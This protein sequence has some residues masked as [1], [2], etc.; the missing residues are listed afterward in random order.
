MKESPIIF[1]GPMVRAILAGRK[2]QTRRII[3]NPE[4]LQGLM[5]AGE[6][7]A[8]CPY[9]GPGDLLYVRESF[10]FDFDFGKHYSNEHQGVHSRH[11]FESYKINY[12]ADGHFVEF[13]FLNGDPV[14]GT[15]SRID[16]ETLAYMS[17]T[18][19]ENGYR[20]SIHMPKWA[21]RI[22]LRVESVSADKLQEITEADAEKEGMCISMTSGWSYS[23]RAAFQ[24]LWD[25]INK[26]RGSWGSNPPVWVV[27]FSIVS[28]TGRPE[29]V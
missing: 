3:K 6:E 8:W 15:S 11:S 27:D 28:T 18:G 21:A 7:P 16:Y 26:D 9:G 10:R 19:P 13:H 20:P 14:E 23:C 4:R 5:L 29:K 24:E 25:K 22:W 2:T 1:S 17:D 12:K